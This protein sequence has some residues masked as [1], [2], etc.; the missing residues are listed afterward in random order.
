MEST[1]CSEAAGLLPNGITTKIVGI[2]CPYRNR[3]CRFKDAATDGREHTAQK[4]SNGPRLG[5]FTD[6]RPSE[7]LG[8]A[9]CQLISQLESTVHA[10]FEAR[11]AARTSF[12]AR[13]MSPFRRST[14]FTA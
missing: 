6:T 13:A 9:L 1:S 14:Y 5:K 8:L 4:S 10:T 7:P 2:G 11:T 3:K 12:A